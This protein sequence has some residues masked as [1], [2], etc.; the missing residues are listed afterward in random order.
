MK[1][2]L[3]YLSLIILLAFIS[4]CGAAKR[5]VNNSSEMTMATPLRGIY[6]RLTAL[7]GESLNQGS[8]TV[9]EAFIKFNIDGKSV[10]GNGGCNSFG[11]SYDISDS[12]HLTFG[13][14]MSTKMYCDNAKFENIFFNI[15]GRTDSY[16]I[17]G[18]TLFLRNKRMDS[19]AKFIADYLKK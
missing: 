10:G 15:L 7:S 4:G 17:S 14:I 8:S 2:F 18:D 1:P 13:P 11:G 6:W 9:K 12:S 3:N 16:L 19:T 5:A